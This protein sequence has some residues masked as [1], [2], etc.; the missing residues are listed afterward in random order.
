MLQPCKQQTPLL[1]ALMLC[2]HMAVQLLQLADNMQ[3][4]QQVLVANSAWLP[5]GSI[6]RSS[7]K[8]QPR[9]EKGTRVTCPRSPAAL[10]GGA[11]RPQ[12]GSNPCS[13]D[14]C[15]PQYACRWEAPPSS[16]TAVCL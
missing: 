15:P 13:W 4:Q 12:Q 6:S 2:S 7:S 9:K 5:T 14:A 3:Q 16:K 10:M 11:S 1:L 8:R